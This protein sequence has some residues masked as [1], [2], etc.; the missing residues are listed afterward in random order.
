MK[1]KAYIC[2]TDAQEHI[3][4]DWNGIDIYFSEESL[5]EHKTCVCDNPGPHGCFPV[6]IEITIPE[7]K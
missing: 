4:D 2:S 3:P 1:Y 6:E 5:R 7:S